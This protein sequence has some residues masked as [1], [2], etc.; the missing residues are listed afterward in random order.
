[1]NQL[2]A[3]VTNIPRPYRRALF[4]VVQKQLAAE[5]LDLRIFYTSDPGKHVRRGA[6][7]AEV[8]DP[9]VESYVR[10]IAFRAGYERVLA[11]PTGLPPALRERR[12]SCVVVGGFGADAI[13]CARWC[14]KTRVPLVI[15]SG[16]WP[17]REGRIGRLSL[18]NRKRLVRKASA[19]V[20]YGSA[21]ADYL[22]S[23]GAAPDRVFRAWNTVDLEGIAESARAAAVRRPE[24]AQKYRLATRNLLYVGTIVESKGLRELVSA[25]LFMQPPGPEWA[26]HFV[27]AG[28]LRQELETTVQTAHMESHF[29]FHGLRPAE[30]VAELLGV[31]DGLLLPTKREAWGL[32]LN[33]AMACGVPVV[34][35]PW[36]GATRDLIEDGV[37]GYVVEPSDIGKLA[38]IMSRLISDDPACRAVGRAGAAA[39]RSKASLEKSAEGF[40]SAVRCAL[41]GHPDG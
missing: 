25:A 29:R 18:M 32:V 13:T 15:W 24:L 41:R 14:R 38:E 21:S 1:V 3:V 22:V 2:V 23:L 9:E 39:V 20:A 40:V 11:L 34:A 37:T 36:A 31:A 8:S 7:A 27:G 26:I 35:S 10:S 17:G 33:E 5:D 4:G 6:P 16:G 19:F 30:D 12:P 28:P